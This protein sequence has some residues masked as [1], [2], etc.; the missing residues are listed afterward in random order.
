MAPSL[1][2]TRQRVDNEIQR[3]E[4]ILGGMTG[5]PANLQYFV[6]EIVLI[7]T[8]SILEIAITE[9]AYKVAA[10]ASY[11]DGSVPTLLINCRSISGAKTAMLTVGHAK[12]KQN[13]KWTRARFITESVRNVIGPNDNFCVTC[14]NFGSQISEIF[15]VRNF[16]AHRNKT[17]RSEFHQ[18]IRAVYGHDLSSQLGYFLLSSNYVPV[19]NLRRYLVQTRVIINDLAKH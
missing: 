2:N 8:A 9:I 10:G 4:T 12:P 13:L 18:V 11:L 1:A 16:A 14:T 5:I 17:S 3:L 15:K 6:A 7:R 19:P